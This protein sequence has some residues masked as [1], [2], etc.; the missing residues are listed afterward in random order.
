LSRSHR[1]GFITSESLKQAK[2]GEHARLL[3]NSLDGRFRPRSGTKH[4]AFGV[5][6]AWFVVV[7]SS[8][9]TFST[10]CLLP[11]NSVNSGGDRPRD[12]RTGKQ[13]RGG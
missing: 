12:P 13:H 9:P 8:T 5:F 7:I 3:K 4:A 11:G 6:E 1:P 10:G 2:F